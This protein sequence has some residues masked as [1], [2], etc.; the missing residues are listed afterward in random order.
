M[1]EFGIWLAVALLGPVSTGPE[2]AA[3][4]TT[5]GRVAYVSK[6]DCKAGF[7]ILALSDTKGEGSGL[8]APFSLGQPGPVNRAALR[9]CVVYRT[10]GLNALTLEN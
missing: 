3:S 7:G 8:S 10:P 6:A 5:D 9:M 2:V 4:R 1:T